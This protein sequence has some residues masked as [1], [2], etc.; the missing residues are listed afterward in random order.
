MTAKCLVIWGRED[1]FIDPVYAERFCELLPD[2]E[3]RLVGA[4]G[5]M[6]PNEEPETVAKAILD[7]A[8]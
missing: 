8:G 6:V 1:K 3:L 5:H 2:A 4:A 7:F